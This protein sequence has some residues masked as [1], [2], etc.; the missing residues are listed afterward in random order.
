MFSHSVY[1]SSA[2]SGQS[3]AIEKTFI[4]STIV[5][6]F[7]DNKKVARPQM[8]QSFYAQTSIVGN[9]LPDVSPSPLDRNKFRFHSVRASKVGKPIA[10]TI[11]APAADGT[12]ALKPNT[13]DSPAPSAFV[14]DAYFPFPPSSPRNFYRPQSFR[15]SNGIPSK[16]ADRYLLNE[17]DEKLS[18]ESS[19]SSGSSDSSDESK[20]IFHYIEFALVSILVNPLFGI[21]ALVLSSKLFFILIY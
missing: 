20:K 6:I 9:S 3:I 4:G 5:R 18:S 8:P 2:I 7:D 11:E 12:Q 21:V 1:N 15:D 14:N 16:P 17:K 19:S 13:Q 10:I